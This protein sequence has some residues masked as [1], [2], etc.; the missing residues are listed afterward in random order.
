MYLS[1]FSLAGKTGVLIDPYKKESTMLEKTTTTV[2][3]LPST[4]R[5]HRAKIAVATTLG[6][7]LWLDRKRV[8]EWNEFLTEHNL[9]ETFYNF[10]E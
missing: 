10:T 9:F 1:I 2:K 6:T 3:S 4:I 8:A 7:V 5:K